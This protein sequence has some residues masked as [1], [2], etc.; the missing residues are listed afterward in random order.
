MSDADRLAQSIVTKGRWAR[1]P[2][3]CSS[4]ATSFLPVPVLPVMS[5]LESLS[6]NRRNL[7]RAHRGGFRR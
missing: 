1:D 2:R 4:L 3:A 7:E 6:A 5:T